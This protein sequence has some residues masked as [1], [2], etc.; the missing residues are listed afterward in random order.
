MTVSDT[1]H[2]QVGALAPTSV[3]TFPAPFRNT[4]VLGKFKVAPLKR[5]V[6]SLPL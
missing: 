5:Q 1:A 2:L 3:P 4:A 6:E